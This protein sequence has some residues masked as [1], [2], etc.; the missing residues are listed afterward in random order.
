MDTY[1]LGVAT[2]WSTGSL[3]INGS[4]TRSKCTLQVNHDQAKMGYI[5]KRPA[6][7]PQPL[8]C[9]SHED[10]HVCK[11]AAYVY[12]LKNVK[13][14]LHIASDCKHTWN[15]NYITF[16]YITWHW[17]AWHCITWLYIEWH[18]STWHHMAWHCITW[19]YM[20]WYR[21]HALHT[22]RTCI[23]YNYITIALH[24]IPLHCIILHSTPYQTIPYRTL[25]HV[26]N[27]QHKNINKH[28]HYIQYIAPTHTICIAHIPL[29]TYIKCI[30]HASGNFHP[31]P[32]QGTN[33]GWQ[34][35]GLITI[36]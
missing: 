12:H 31:K 33:T 27:I 25:Q 5:S 13:C 34:S 30:L 1:W 32:V 9:K 10:I 8:T 20:S 22:L 3:C 36:N 7:D 17:I 16:H 18:C 26:Q 15:Y 11:R 21:I 29:T 14:I 35:R 23:H 19:H 4:V 24:Y 6:A 28:T 2:N